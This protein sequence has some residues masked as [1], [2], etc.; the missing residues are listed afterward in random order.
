MDKCYY[1]FMDLIR[2]N[3]IPLLK[4]FDLNPD[5][6]VIMASGLLAL[7]GIRE[8]NDLDIAVMPDYFDELHKSKIFEEK[9]Q[10]NNFEINPVLTT[11]CR[12]IEFFPNASPLT[13]DVLSLIVRSNPIQGINFLCLDDFIQWKLASDRK[14]DR[15]D[16]ELMKKFIR[17]SANKYS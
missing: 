4:S 9:R 10:G 17:E 5:Q 7:L 1:G 8:N 6:F 12:C 11:Q 2:V 13:D 3:H 16:L 14:K 15:N